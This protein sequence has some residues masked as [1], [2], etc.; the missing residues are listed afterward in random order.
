MQQKKFSSHAKI[1]LAK[2]RCKT[3]APT[4]ASHIAG[5][6]TPSKPMR[7]ERQKL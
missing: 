6:S 5:L 4:T 2:R 1:N 3:F 7:V